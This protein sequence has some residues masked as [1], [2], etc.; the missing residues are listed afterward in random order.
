MLKRW[1]GGEVWIES[2]TYSGSTTRLLSQFS[3]RIISIEPS[4]ELYA[5][6]KRRMARY[7]NIELIQGTS[8]SR[9][10]SVIASLVDDGA[11]DLSF[12]LDG[13]YSGGITFRGD[14]DTPIRQE[15]N[16]ISRYISSLD[17]IT[18]CVDDVRI[19][20]PSAMG[21]RNY[22]SLT[23][24][25]NWSDSHHLFWTIEHD[26]FVATNRPDSISAYSST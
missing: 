14:N 25:V 21:F 26:I 11:R 9:L 7:R 15:L 8:E 22:P 3:K 19:F 20:N 4:D 2:G 10:D 5:A 17:F 1:G 23:Y 24:L 12:W 6:A 13:H 16:T 18:V